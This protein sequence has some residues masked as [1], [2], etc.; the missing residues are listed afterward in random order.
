[1]GVGGVDG[2]GNVILRGRGGCGTADA[3]MADAVRD[4]D[5]T[6][7]S[8]ATIGAASHAASTSATS[9]VPVMRATVS[10]DNQQ[11]TPGSEA[12]AMRHLFAS[13]VKMKQAGSPEKMVYAGQCESNEMTGGSARSSPRPLSCRQ[14]LNAVSHSPGHLTAA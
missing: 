8:V 2:V 7:S 10:M 1:M 3:D 5:W 11:S 14:L 9:M 4:D 6:R 13:K 12:A